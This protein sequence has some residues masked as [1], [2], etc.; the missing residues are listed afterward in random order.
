VAQLDKDL[1]MIEALRE[2]RVELRGYKEVGL[3][4]FDSINILLSVENAQ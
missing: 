2:L 4:V 3:N 1:A